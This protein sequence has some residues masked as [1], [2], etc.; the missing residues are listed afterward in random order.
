MSPTKRRAVLLTGSPKTPQASS[1]ARIGRSILQGL[2]GAGWVCRELH[3]HAAVTQEDAGGRLD[4]AIQG[5]HLVILAVPLYVD[6]LP[7][8]VVRGLRE[9]STCRGSR[10]GRPVPRVLSVML[11][12]YVE[13]R[14]AD[15][16]QRMVRAFCRQT[17]LGWA[18]SV[19]L[20]S[21]GMMNR[22][23]R[24]ALDGVIEAVDNEQEIPES[25]LRTLRRPLMP[26]WLY[27]AA[28]NVMWRRLAKANKVRHRLHDRPYQ[29]G[30]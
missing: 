5:T 16:A 29:I 6:G 21:G 12:G 13:P 22:R 17:G 2:E 27:C 20:G 15:V 9:L 14:Q 28:G 18:G 10:E 25:V 26:T 23:I 19:S 4:D 1:S 11:C 30:P 3:I 24:V 7:G 8:P